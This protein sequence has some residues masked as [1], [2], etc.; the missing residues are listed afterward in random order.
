[1]ETE[2]EDEVDFNEKGRGFNCEVCGSCRRCEGRSSGRFSV[3]DTAP[4]EPSEDPPV[5][6]GAAVPADDVSMEEVATDD[7]ST[8]T[9]ESTTEDVFTEDTYTW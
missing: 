7:A 5:L 3:E 8:H 9:E 4:E 2:V 6:K 1:M